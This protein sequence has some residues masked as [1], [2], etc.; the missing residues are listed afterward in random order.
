M[1]VNLP[2]RLLRL[3]MSPSGLWEGQRDVNPAF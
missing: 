1:T 2:L 3:D